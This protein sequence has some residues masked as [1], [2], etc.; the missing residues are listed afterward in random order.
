MTSTEIVRRPQPA[1][2]LPDKM[3][4]AEKLAESG[5]LPAA[6]R[7][8]PANVLYAIEYGDMLNLSPMAALTG[9]HIIDGKPTAS[10]ALIS[11]L[12][13]RAGHRLRIGYDARTKTGW[14]KIV[15]SDDPDF[16]FESEWDLKRAVDAEL[17]TVD[18]DGN[19]RAVDSKGNSKPWKKFYPSMV[20][21]RAI[22]EVARDA[23]EE[24]LFGLHYTPEELGADVD[25]DGIPIAVTAERLDPP[26]PQPPTCDVNWD[27]ELA[28]HEGDLD[29]LRALYRRAGQEDPNNTALADR[30]TEAATRA[31]QL[32]QVPDAAGD[33][34]VD[35]EIVDEQ[36]TA[37]PVD[38]PPA[39]KEQLRQLNVELRKVKLLADRDKRLA[40]VSELVGRRLASTGELTSAEAGNVLQQLA[41]WADPETADAVIFELLANP[42]VMA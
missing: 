34:V 10:A 12:V 13:R 31:S 22:T 6:Y 16:T 21:A 24:A 40:V 29:G 20:K 42:Q 7:A 4:Y 15:R 19:P 39:T 33:Q 18:K 36:T 35:A 27:A 41:K 5:L 30:I 25:E 1:A 14:A 28:K 26:K 3:A 37:E 11:A 2:S 9:V 32:A 23:C 38:P 17:C 8:R